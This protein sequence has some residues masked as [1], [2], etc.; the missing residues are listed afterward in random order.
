MRARKCVR[1]HTHRLHVWQVTRCMEHLSTRI[2]IFS[3]TN[4]IFS[5]T[6][7]IF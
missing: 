2:I 5:N 1:A 6:I 4:F 7:F 3:N